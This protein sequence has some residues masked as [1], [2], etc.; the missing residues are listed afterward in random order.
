MT[1]H[2]K[3]R[4]AYRGAIGASLLISLAV[5][6]GAS[7]AQAAEPNDGDRVCYA[8]GSTSSFIV[9]DGEYVEAFFDENGGGFCAQFSYAGESFSYIGGYGQLADSRVGNL[10]NVAITSIT[11]ADLT[12]GGPCVIS[13]NSWTDAMAV[14]EYEVQNTVGCMHREVLGDGGNL[15]AG[16]DPA[17]GDYVCHAGGAASAFIVIAERYGDDYVN[18][19]G[20]GL[21]AQFTYGGESFL[22]VGRYGNVA[23][24]TVANLKN[25]AITRLTEND[26]GPD[27]P[28]VEPTGEVGPAAYEVRHLVGCV[29]LG[30]LPAELPACVPITDGSAGPDCDYN[31]TLTEPSYKAGMG[32]T[33]WVDT[34]HNN[35]H[36]ITPRS[37]SEPG[38][39][40]GFASLLFADGYRV[41]DSTVPLLELRPGQQPD[42]LVLA[43]ARPAGGES[44]DAVEEEEAEGIVQWVHEGGSLLVI[45]DHYPMDQIGSL[46]L[47][48][49]L[50]V[51]PE[52]V[53]SEPNHEFSQTDETLIDSF[54]TQG[55]AGSRPV[56]QVTSFYGSTMDFA[57]S[58]PG[59]EYTPIMT[60]GSGAQGYGSGVEET[61]SLE[62]YMQG[63]QIEYG[64]GRALVFSEARMFTAMSQS[65]SGDDSG[66]PIIDPVPA[67]SSKK[68]GMHQTEFNEAFLLNAVGWLNR[69]D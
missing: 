32:P 34:M 7:I 67:G 38:R 55:P 15:A 11:E 53:G 21:C 39:Y 14:G 48:L 13:S 28:C 59:A 60:F 69:Q 52:G 30:P 17:A 19:N 61:V 8:G 27:A 62:G 4:P 35:F 54:L 33:V 36:Q 2:E 18:Q 45:A 46:L 41:Q 47:A 26:L 44:G 29:Y 58:L 40:W 42:V 16:E 1:S 10:K 24:S 66:S 51:K 37:E 68:T 25:V 12:E 57:E 23:D 63:V 22:S 6:G 31:P 65:E 5:V 43:N 64:A 50:E 3:K 9:L 49:G 20:G 56:D